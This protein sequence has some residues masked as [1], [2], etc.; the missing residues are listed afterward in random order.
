MHLFPSHDWIREDNN[1]NTIE[2]L[3]AVQERL[4]LNQKELG[5]YAG[6]STRTINSWLTGYRACPDHVAE[7]IRRVAEM[8]YQALQDGDE[9]S[10][11]QRWCL[12]RSY[13]IDE[14]MTAYGSQADAMRDAQ[15]EWDHMTEKEKTSAETFEVILADVCL[16]DRT[17]DGCFGWAGD[18]EV[19]EVAK[20]WIE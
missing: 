11:M 12:V 15:I 6:V 7:L 16:I 19:R 8:D 1:M 9:T 3:K 4:G 20:N 18:G 17:I 10:I 14:F 5:V 2:T 13:G